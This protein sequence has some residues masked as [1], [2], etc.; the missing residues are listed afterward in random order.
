MLAICRGVQLVNVARG[1]TLHRHLPDHAV[2]RD[3]QVEL[4]SG[5]TL[6]GL[7]GSA[8]NVNS[9]HHQSVC[10][11][12]RDALIASIEQHARQR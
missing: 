6:A 10:R 11:L 7:Y 5:S 4:T 12:G 8:T 9:L 2:G 3:H 1:G